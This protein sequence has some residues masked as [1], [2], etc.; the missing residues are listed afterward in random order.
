MAKEQKYLGM[1]VVK[2]G[3][4]YF[5]DCA[6]LYFARSRKEAASLLSEDGDMKPMVVLTEKEAL[7]MYDLLTALLKKPKLSQKQLLDLIEKRLK[8]EERV[9]AKKHAAQTKATKK[10]GHGV[11]R[12]GKTGT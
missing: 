4:G 10:P 11:R 1:G 6:M 9:K 3:S 5:V 2:K 12:T 8:E 7:E